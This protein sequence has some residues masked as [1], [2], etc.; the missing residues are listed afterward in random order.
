MWATTA[1]LWAGTSHAATGRMKPCVAPATR[2]NLL[3]FFINSGTLLCSCYSKI[4]QTSEKTA[5]FSSSLWLSAYPDV[6]T[7]GNGSP[8]RSTSGMTTPME[9]GGLC[10][11][12]NKRHSGFKRRCKLTRYTADFCDKRQDER[13]RRLQPEEKTARQTLVRHLAQRQENRS[14]G[15]HKKR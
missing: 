12:E 10:E 13:H 4:T 9:H 8:C 2:Q 15:F 3:S 1:A 14:S 7:L 11:S 6:R 5:S